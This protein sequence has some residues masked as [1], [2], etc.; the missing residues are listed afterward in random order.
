MHPNITTYR[1]VKGA[2]VA[3]GGSLSRW[4]R[5]NH[6]CLSY[7]QKV[8]K[9]ERSGKLSGALYSKIVSA[10]GLLIDE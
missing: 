1:I 5:E 9:G 6:I 3:Q 10:A 4:C 7:A 8:L 2:F